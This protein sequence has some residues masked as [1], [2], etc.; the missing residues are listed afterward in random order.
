MVVTSIIHTG[1]QQWGCLAL[2]NLATN[3]AYNTIAIAAA[4]G[5]GVVVTS[6]TVHPS[7]TGVQ[8]MGCGA[9]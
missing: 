3:N 2:S 9:L 1:V 8:E 6:M 7:H 5:I 4:G